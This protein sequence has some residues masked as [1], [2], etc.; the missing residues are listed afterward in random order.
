M[1]EYV[2][3]EQDGPIVTISLNLAEKR[4]PISEMGMVDA[5]V[6]SLERIQNDESVRVAILT[7]KGTAFS[8]GGDQIGRA[9]V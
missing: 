5:I 4:N 9:H 3:Y 2:V 1:T 8:S 6:E 7:G